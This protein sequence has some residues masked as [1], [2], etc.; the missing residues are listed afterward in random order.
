[1]QGAISFALLLSL[2]DFV[3]HHGLFHLQEFYLL[4]PGIPAFLLVIW[5]GFAGTTSEGFGTCG[6]SHRSRGGKSRNASARS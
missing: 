2:Y 3:V 1:M 4:D 5:H 6:F